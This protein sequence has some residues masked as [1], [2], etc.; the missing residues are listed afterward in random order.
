MK[1]ILIMMLRL[2]RNYFSCSEPENEFSVP[3]IKTV[4]NIQEPR[5][6]SQVPELLTSLMLLVTGFPARAAMTSESYAIPS[7]T[8]SSGGSVVM[9]GQ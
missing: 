2:V 3:R 8:I 9:E 5:I 1:K 6:Y 7:L 4:K